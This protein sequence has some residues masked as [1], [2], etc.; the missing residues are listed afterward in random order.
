MGDAIKCVAIIN[1]Y[2]NQIIFLTS[3][4]SGYLQ[5]F[6]EELDNMLKTFHSLHSAKKE[7]SKIHSNTG[8]WYCKV[9]SRKQVVFVD[10]VS[11]NYPSQSAIRLISDVEEE[12]YKIQ[13]F[14]KQDLKNYLNNQVLYLMKNYD[15]DPDFNDKFKNLEQSIES[16]SNIMGENISKIS[17]NKEDLERI[18]KKTVEMDLM[19]TKFKNESSAL[20]RKMWWQKYSSWIVMGVIF[21]ILLIILIVIIADSDD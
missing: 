7:I 15:N 17:A 21:I 5:Y 8:T 18:E 6:A 10:L 9:N 1:L 13:D 19:A 20:K 12:A 2:N 3:L 4:R 11:I 14:E 16:I